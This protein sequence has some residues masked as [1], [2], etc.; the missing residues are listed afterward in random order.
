VVERSRLDE[1]LDLLRSNYPGLE[2][3]Q[4][5][6]WVRFPEYVVPVEIWGQSTVEVSFQIPERIPGQAPYGFFVRPHMTLRNQQPVGNYAY[7]AQTAFGGDW[8]KFS[9]QLL[10]W[11]PSANVVAGTNM[12]NFARSIGDRFREGA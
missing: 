2:Y 1:E 8:G 10:V 7:P 9:W 11:E 5:G 12:V 3:R 6:H 4:E